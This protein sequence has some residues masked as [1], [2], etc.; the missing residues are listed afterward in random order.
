MNRRTNI[1]GRL[2]RW[3]SGAAR[4]VIAALAVTYWSAAM[5]P[6]AMAAMHEAGGALHE[7]TVVHDGPAHHEQHASNGHSHHGH[8]AH[9]GSAAAH[10]HGA[11]APAEHCPHCPHA[12]GSSSAIACDDAQVSCLSVDDLKNAAA[13]HAKD[14]PQPLVPLLGPAAFTLPPSLASPRAS[15]PL[16]AAPVALVPLNVR[17]CVFLI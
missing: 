17:N 12:V 3:K 13:S 8:E 14:S 15:P 9:G 7:A 10:D 1:L 11:P 2:R 5:A 16:R 6:C 4:Y